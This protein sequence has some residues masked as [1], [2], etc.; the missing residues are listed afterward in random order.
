M[1]SFGLKANCMDVTETAPGLYEYDSDLRG[2]VAL[3]QLRDIW[4][5]RDLVYQLIRRDIVSR[6]KR[7]TLGIAWTL[8]NPLGMMVVLT[9]RVL[10][11]IS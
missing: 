10:P 11:G 4:K 9:S 1:E 2:P 8:L 7:S 5:Y 6:Y 3:E